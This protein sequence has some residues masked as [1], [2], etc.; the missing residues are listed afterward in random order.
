MAPSFGATYI[1]RC[2]NAGAAAEQPV[3]GIDAF[4]D[5]FVVR[6]LARPDRNVC[7]LIDRLAFPDQ[8][9]DSGGGIGGLQQRAIGAALHPLHDGICVGLEPDRDRLARDTAAGLFTH[10]SAAAGSQHGWTAIEQASDHPR[11]A[12][13]EMPLAV[14][15]K[16]I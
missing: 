13:P 11:L 15:V 10:E 1:V 9:P 7:V 14:V 2:F 16:Y 6:H 8:P 4:I 3:Q 5:D 12:I